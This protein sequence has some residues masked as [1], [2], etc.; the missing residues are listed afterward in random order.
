[1]KRSPS[2][3][4]VL[5]GLAGL[6][7]VALI[8]GVVWFTAHQTPLTRG[9][10]ASLAGRITSGANA[11]T[12]VQAPSG[13]PGKTWQT[14]NAENASISHHLDGVAWSGSQFVIVGYTDEFK[15]IILTSP[16]G[17]TWT[18]QNSGTSDL[19]APN[20]AW[21]DTQF[22]IV[23]DNGAIL[24]SP[25]GRTWTA[26]NSGTLNSLARVAWSGTR[27]VV[28]CDYGTILTSP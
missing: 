6:V 7:I 16:D 2:R 27:F 14:Q 17:R 12:T 25:D 15:A 19:F 13:I 26:Q 10:Q 21:L 3:R 5:V 9:I 18:A 1:M 23:G 22:V 20:V 11:T 4:I 24:T 28:V 8:R